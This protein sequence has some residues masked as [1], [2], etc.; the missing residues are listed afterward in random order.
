MQIA[1]NRVNELLRLTG[2]QLGEA[3]QRVE[4]EAT[5]TW[6]RK[7]AAERLNLCSRFDGYL[8]EIGELPTRPDPDKELLVNILAGIRDIFG[9]DAE[10][11]AHHLHSERETELLEAVR[12]A[13]ELVHDVKA[14]ILLAAAREHLDRAQSEAPAFPE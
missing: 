2:D 3:A 12:G 9:D 1:L 14:C 5:A 8:R 4:D 10:V 6:L 11:P 13:Q 7:L